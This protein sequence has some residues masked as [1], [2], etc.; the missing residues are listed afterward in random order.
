MDAKLYI[1]T[2][3]LYNKSPLVIDDYKAVSLSLI[4]IATNCY[5]VLETKSQGTYI[6][7]NIVISMYIF[8]T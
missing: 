5:F 1:T 3:T 8:Y 6:F 7:T 2:H 4:Y